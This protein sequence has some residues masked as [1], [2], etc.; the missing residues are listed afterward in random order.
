MSFFPNQSRDRLVDPRPNI[1][2]RAS[3]MR[4]L[5]NLGTNRI[6]PYTAGGEILVVGG[7]SSA[8]ALETNSQG[9]PVVVK[10]AP[11]SV[12]Q[13]LVATSATTAEWQNASVPG[14]APIDAPYVLYGAPDARLPNSSLLTFNG[15]Q[16]DETIVVG[17]PTQLTGNLVDTGVVANTYLDP[18]I[19]VNDN[20]LITSATNP[21]VNGPAA[22]SPTFSNIGVGLGGWITMADNGSVV[23]TG[24]F[25]RTYIIKLQ[26]QTDS[27]FD[28]DALNPPFLEFT[29]TN[30]GLTPINVTSAD[31]GVVGIIVLTAD[32]TDSNGDGYMSVQAFTPNLRF[33]IPRAA[34]LDSTQYNIYA[35]LSYPIT[36]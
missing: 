2:W 20:G 24:K 26:G 17:P 7:V 34:V 35:L 30:V 10:S 8:Q 18:E 11:P 5:Y 19:V 13:I 23:W 27:A 6:Q 31:F 29:I 33:Q 25:H 3:I 4:A 21:Y 1:S 22:F 36:L 16:F 12:N 15:A 32:E 9:N 14:V 28:L